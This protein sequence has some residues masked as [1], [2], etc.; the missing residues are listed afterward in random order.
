MKNILTLAAVACLAVGATAQTLVVYPTNG[1]PIVYQAS[2]I[3]HI[4]FVPATGDEEDKPLEVYELWSQ[5]GDYRIYGKMYRPA[6]TADKPLPTVILSHSASLT[7]DAM[8]AYATA[9][10]EAGYCA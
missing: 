6:L 7:A 8:N 9:I 10:A 2:E 4:E 1:E 3:D 5:R